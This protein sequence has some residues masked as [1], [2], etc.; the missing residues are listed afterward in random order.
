MAQGVM[1][2]EWDSAVGIPDKKTGIPDMTPRYARNCF[3]YDPHQWLNQGCV[4]VEKS[5]HTLGGPLNENG[6]GVFAL[7]WDPI[8][9]HIRTWVFSPH[10]SLPS[11]IRDSIRTASAKNES[12]RIMPDP[13]LWPTPYGYFAIGDE[14]NCPSFHFKNMRLVFNQ[15]FCGSVAGNRFEMDCPEQ[16][17]EF[18]TCEDW[19]KSVPKEM[20][21]AYWKIRG[22][23]VYERAWE[24]AWL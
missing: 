21:E 5:N 20:D 7:E 23:Y 12:D 14:T 11:N 13:N 24:R 18:E 19:I 10:R 3:V 8:N 16:A 4:A 17:Q 6:G 2:G 22:V 9:R 1:D 15:A